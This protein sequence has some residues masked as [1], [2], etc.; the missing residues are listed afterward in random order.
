M[1]FSLPCS[2]HKSSPI[3]EQFMH[4][5]LNNRQHI[6]QLHDC[7]L[8]GRNTSVDNVLLDEIGEQVFFACILLSGSTA[9]DDLLLPVSMKFVISCLFWSFYDLKT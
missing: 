7:R 9:L 1:L 4:S 5:K 2:I 8:T 3:P 6:L